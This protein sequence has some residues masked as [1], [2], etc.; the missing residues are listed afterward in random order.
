MLGRRCHRVI[1]PSLMAASVLALVASAPADAHAP[2][3]KKP[4]A[5]TGVTAI[6]VSGDVDVS[7]T[8]PS[9]DGGSPITGYRV[10]T[11]HGG[12]SCTTGGA[13]AC[14]VTGLTAGRVYTVR[15][16]AANVKSEGPRSLPI[17]VLLLPTISWVDQFPYSGG[18][19]T[20]TL[21][22]STSS[23]VRV[24][25]KTSDGPNFALRWGEWIGAASS[26]SPSSGTVTFAPGQT[27]ATILFTVNPTNVSGCSPFFP[28]QNCWPSATVTLVNPANAVL[29]PTPYTTLAFS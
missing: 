29:G 26:F 4:G 13:L 3:I 25:F 15:V 6:Q 9:S 14:T 18:P 16:R 10:T 28:P 21:T 2:K 27:T 1:V 8:P 19:V 11:S 24:D 5:P 22:H 7:W 20:L 17:Q 12:K 23:P